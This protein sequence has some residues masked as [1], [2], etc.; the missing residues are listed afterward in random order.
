MSALRASVHCNIR[1]DIVQ[2]LPQML[3]S[4][5]PYV[6]VFRRARDMLRDHCE[7]FVLQIRIIQT[8]E[9]R[10]YIR[11]TIEEVAGLLVVDGTEHLGSRNITIQKMNGTL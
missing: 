1:A 4:V 2:G 8:R 6:I 11:P 7:V 10:Q 3:D 9:G 5:N